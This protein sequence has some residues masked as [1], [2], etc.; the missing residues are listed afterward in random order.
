MNILVCNV[1][2]IMITAIKFRLEKHNFKMIDSPD[3]KA[4][5]ESV[6]NGEADFVIVGTD[7]K[8]MPAAEVIHHV[9]NVLKS[10]I[11]FIVVANQE[12]GEEILEYL[13]AGANDFVLR[14][15]KPMELVLRIKRIINNSN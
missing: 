15:F 13:K 10:D 14:P 7:V 4:A 1:E 3:G 9:R 11:P 8:E 2:D 12:E 6:E 5:V